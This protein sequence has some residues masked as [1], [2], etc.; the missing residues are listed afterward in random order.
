MAPIPFS[1]PPDD[2]LSVSQFD[3]THKR[4]GLG[5]AADGFEGLTDS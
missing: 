2:F 3:S 1:A 5:M 4:N